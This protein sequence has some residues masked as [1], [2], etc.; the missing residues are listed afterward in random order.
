ME[1]V[2]WRNLLLDAFGVKPE[3]FKMKQSGSKEGEC[4]RSKKLYQ[5][6]LETKQNVIFLSSL[7]NQSISNFNRIRAL[8]PQVSNSQF[9]QIWMRERRNRDP[10]A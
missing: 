5:F 1:D 10:V 3:G 6:M 2:L 8:N 4:L 7:K 9:Q